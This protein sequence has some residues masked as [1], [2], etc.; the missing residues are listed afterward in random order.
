MRDY[1]NFYIDGHHYAE[2][3]NQMPAAKSIG[4]LPCPPRVPAGVRDCLILKVR[5]WAQ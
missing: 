1:L 5:W 3:D 4:A 2:V